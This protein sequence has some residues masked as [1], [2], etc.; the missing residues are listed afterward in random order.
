MAIYITDPLKFSHFLIY[1]YLLNYIIKN[2]CIELCLI[3]FL[4]FVFINKKLKGVFGDLKL[5]LIRILLNP[6]LMLTLFTFIW[7]KNY[8]HDALDANFYLFGLYLFVFNF[9]LP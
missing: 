1:D 3:I 7:V 9:L 2:I 4:F 8:S 6:I 5:I